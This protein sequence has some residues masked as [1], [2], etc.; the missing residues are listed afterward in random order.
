MGADEATRRARELVAQALEVD[1]DT[2]AGE[3]R[4][5]ELKGFDSLA[6]ERLV[7]ATEEELGRDLEPL[8]MVSVETVADL[9]RII[10]DG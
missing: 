8:A 6:Y 5:A 4:I 7:A 10:A 2:I 9:G 3:A 1:P